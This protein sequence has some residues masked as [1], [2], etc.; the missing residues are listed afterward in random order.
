MRDLW[1]YL[2][3]LLMNRNGISVR[4][5]PAT[6]TEDNDSK[7]EVDT[8]NKEEV[9]FW[10]NLSKKLATDIAYNLH[11]WSYHPLTYPYLCSLMCTLKYIY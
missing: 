4:Y 3:N 11:S 6:P 1:T 8:D 9:H 2:L 7:G 10:I 5:A